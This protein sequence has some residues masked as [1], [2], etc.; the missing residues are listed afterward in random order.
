MG[1]KSRSDRWG[2]LV[3]LNGQGKPLW[4]MNN[5]YEDGTL[6]EPWMQE[7]IDRFSW[8]IPSDRF[9]VVWKEANF[10]QHDRFFCT[11]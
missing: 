9:M 4:E 8:G 6:P 10:S 7:L 5:Y 3:G 11:L 2:Q 1:E